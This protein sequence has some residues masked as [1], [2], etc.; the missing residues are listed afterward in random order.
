LLK[1]AGHVIVDPKLM[2]IFAEAPNGR[3]GGQ[4]GGREGFDQAW[5]LVVV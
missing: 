5:M 1:A 2:E 3:V 4:S